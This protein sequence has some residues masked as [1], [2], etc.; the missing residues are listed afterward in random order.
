MISHKNERFRKLFSRLLI[1]IQKKTNKAYFIFKQD[2]FY[3]SLHFRRV[4]STRP[5]YSVRIT[6][7]YRAVGILMDS[8]IIWFWVGSHSEYNRLLSQLRNA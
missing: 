5:I 3:P 2:P 4:H 7:D 6:D 1:E 8:A